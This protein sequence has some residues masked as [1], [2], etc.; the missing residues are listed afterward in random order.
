MRSAR[1]DAGGGVS[2]NLRKHETHALKEAGDV[3]AGGDGYVADA[4]HTSAYVSIRQHTSRACWR[5]RR[6]RY[7]GCEVGRYVADVRGGGCRAVDAC[8]RQYT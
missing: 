3:P 6:G 1:G 5:R 4:L 7:V 8:I 2:A